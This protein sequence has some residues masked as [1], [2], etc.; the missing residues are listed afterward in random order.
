MENFTSGLE[1]KTD[2]GY[3]FCLHILQHFSTTRG[4][5]AGSPEIMCCAEEGGS[6]RFFSWFFP[7]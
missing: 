4:A 3:I 7:S 1:K 6:G 5:P 2:T